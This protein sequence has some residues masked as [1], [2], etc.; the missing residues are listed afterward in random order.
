MAEEFEQG[1]EPRDYTKWIW[2]GIAVAAVVLL[3]AL[4]LSGG[5]ASSNTEASVKHI[6]ISFSGSDPAARQR[7]LDTVT[8]LRERLEA[9]EDF[10]KLAEE[11][12]DD[13]QSAARG[14]YLGWA[15][16]GTYEKA[17]DEYVWSAPVGQLSPVIQTGFG[18][19]LIVVNE[20][21]LSAADQYD[22][23]L[24]EQVKKQA[25]VIDVPPLDNLP[26]AQPASAAPPAP[27]EAVPAPAAPA[28]APAGAQ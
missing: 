22:R 5:K 6:L 17:F 12:S 9:G 1:A 14:G 3:G 11:Y 10:A 25:P 27:A 13:P 8:G 21:R 7:A 15:P 18:Y 24:E 26:P 4:S 19:H 20:R 28:P 2:G 23:Q 16:K